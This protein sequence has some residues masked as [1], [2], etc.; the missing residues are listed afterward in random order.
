MYIV[1]SG[2]SAMRIKELLANSQ[3]RQKRARFVMSWYDQSGAPEAGG[4]VLF[5]S[6]SFD[7]S[8]SSCLR[9]LDFAS[10]A[11]TSLFAIDT[12]SLLFEIKFSTD[13]F[14]S[15]SFLSL[16]SEFSFGFLNMPFFFLSTSALFSS[17]RFWWRTLYS[18]AR[19]ICS[20]SLMVA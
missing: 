9:V 5:D 18:R 2:K 3:S 15:G 14:R 17:S 8:N 10:E 20:A 7:P 6:A 16:F 13:F 1:S 11:L 12:E 4:V 19:K